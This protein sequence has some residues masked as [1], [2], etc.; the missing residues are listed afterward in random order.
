M[1][2][3]GFEICKGYE[4]S[5]IS[6][7]VRKTKNSAGYDFESAENVTIPSIWKSVADDLDKFTFLNLIPLANISNITS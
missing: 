4:E 7:P 5:D 1:K 6:L 3:R 2:I